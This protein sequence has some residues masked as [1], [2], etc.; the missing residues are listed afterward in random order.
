MCS[1]HAANGKGKAGVKKSNLEGIKKP[2]IDEKKEASSAVW[3][4]LLIQRSWKREVGVP[5]TLQMT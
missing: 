2:S 1:L 4:P 5:R 3:E